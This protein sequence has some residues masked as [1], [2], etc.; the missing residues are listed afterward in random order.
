MEALSLLEEQQLFPTALNEGLSV[1]EACQRYLSLSP[2]LLRVLDEVLLR[3]MECVAA[4]HRQVKGESD[5]AT[6]REMR[7]LALRRRASALVGLTGAMK[8]HLCKADTASKLARM[9]VTLV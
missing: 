7:L 4:I 2:L 5:A 9:E 1:S 8:N 6:N 3:A